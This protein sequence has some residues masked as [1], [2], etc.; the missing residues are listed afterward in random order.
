MP[1]I[2]VLNNTTML[3]V[4][5]KGFCLPVLSLN[6]GKIASRKHEFALEET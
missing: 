2:T 4:S 6:N 3:K 1:N 5:K